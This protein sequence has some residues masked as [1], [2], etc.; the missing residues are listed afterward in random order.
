MELDVV[1]ADES[2][3]VIDKPPGLVVHPGAGNWSGT[4]LNGL[5]AY[6][7]QQARLPRAGIVHR[8]D[9][10]TSGLMVIARTSAAQLELVRQLQTRTV[11][12]EYWA[13]VHGMAPPQGWVDR[14]IARDPRQPLRFKVSAGVKAKPARTRYRRV[15]TAEVEGGA[16][17]WLECH[18]DT[19]RTHQIRVHLESI[20]LPLVGDAV[21]RRGRPTGAGRAA[22]PWARFS[23][24]ALHACRL[25]LLH[26][27][28][29]DPLRWFRLPPAD[30]RGLMAELGFDP[31]RGVGAGR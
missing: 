20:G 15:D 4:L 16:F 30:M 8:L 19:G 18:L 2:I 1:Y 14:A 27:R 26:P 23:R 21:Y 7:A 29:G 5:L 6:D 11:E 25:G 13:V 22:T 28:S 3:L 10:D 24:Q 9:A 12:R 17:S 31:G